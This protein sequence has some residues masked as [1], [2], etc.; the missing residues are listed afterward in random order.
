M[1]GSLINA[2]VLLSFPARRESFWTP[3]L[4]GFSASEP[5]WFWM[6]MCRS[7]TRL[8]S[9]CR[10]F[11]NTGQQQLY[12][13]RVSNPSDIPCRIPARFAWCLL[14]LVSVC[15]RPFCLWG[16]LYISLVDRS[17]EIR[18]INSYYPAALELNS[19]ATYCSP[20]LWSMLRKNRVFT[21]QVE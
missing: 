12:M 2:G 13:P 5:T 9:K 16:T 4:V 20:A 11:G 10:G 14:H 15:T 3:I 1:T 8:V 18:H 17:L 6:R 7:L 21:D 19:S